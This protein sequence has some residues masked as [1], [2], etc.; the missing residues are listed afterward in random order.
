MLYVYFVVSRLLPL[1][2][3]LSL[4]LTLTLSS[5]F[6][7]LS[8]CLCE[9]IHFG[10]G[11]FI[12]LLY[13]YKFMSHLLLCRCVI[14]MF[15]YFSNF[16]ISFVGFVREQCSSSIPKQKTK[17]EIFFFRFYLYSESNVHLHP[18]MMTIELVARKLVALQFLHLFTVNIQHDKCLYPD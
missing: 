14:V 9:Q 12:V 10:Q 17:Y 13:L 15:L 1:F 7:S 3:S 6:F 4:S 8:C 5:Q 16:V 11:L 2:G 18:K